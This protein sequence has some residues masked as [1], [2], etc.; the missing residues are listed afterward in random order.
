MNALR[1]WLHKL[2]ELLHANTKQ[3][4]R[5]LLLAFLPFITV[6]VMM[7]I[8]FLRA[9]REH[10]ISIL[11][12]VALQAGN[13]MGFLYNIS[14]SIA[15]HVSNSLILQDDVLL[16]PSDSEDFQQINRNIL[17]L[18]SLVN[19]YQFFEEISSIRFFLPENLIISD[20]KMLHYISVLQD[21]EWYQAYLSQPL[22]H[23]WYLTDDFSGDDEPSYVSL[24]SSVR[25]PNDY[26]Q[27]IGMLSVDISLNYM[28]DIL[29]TG[30]ILEQT[31]GFLVDCLG[32]VILH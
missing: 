27:H 9:Q 23:R 12:D 13:Q 1:N 18:N 26:L 11:Q 6:S 3:F 15:Q 7:N 4:I 21:R 5:C 22:L 17:K 8:R 28:A 32:Q 29:H 24:V 31:D 16:T 19:T 2:H 14:A 20:E 25:N 10:T 30:M